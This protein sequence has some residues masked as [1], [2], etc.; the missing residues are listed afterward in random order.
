MPPYIESAYT[1]L[2]G[3]LHNP[4]PSKEVKAVF[5][6]KT[7]SSLKDIDNWFINVRKKI[8]WNKLR[9]KHYRNKRSEIVDAATRFFRELPYTL[10]GPDITPISHI[11][12]TANHDSEFK[13]IEIRA[14]E[15]YSDKLFETALTTKMN[16][17]VRDVMLETKSRVQAVEKYHKQAAKSRRGNNPRRS[18]YPSPERSPGRSP[19]PSPVKFPE[20]SGVSPLPIPNAAPAS[21]RKRRNSDRDSPEFDIEYRRDEPQKRSRYILSVYSDS[22]DITIDILFLDWTLIKFPMTWLLPVYLLQRHPCLTLLRKALLRLRIKPQRMTVS[23][24][25]LSQS[26]LENVNAVYRMQAMSV[27]PSAHTMLW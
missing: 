16:G 5:A 19:E 7:N 24:S 22:K 11:D 4:Y 21:S 12:L 15:L 10:H 8:G 25:Q 14:K 9:M 6:H 1:W 20:P 2:L 17:A 23:F 3:N 27:L 13:A 18:A 26:H